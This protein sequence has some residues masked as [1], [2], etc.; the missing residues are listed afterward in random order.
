MKFVYHGMSAHLSAYNALVEQ[1]LLFGEKTAIKT[2]AYTVLY[3]GKLAHA[4]DTL[5]TGHFGHVTGDLIGDL[6]SDAVTD[7]SECFQW[8]HDVAAVSKSPDLTVLSVRVRPW[9]PLSANIRTFIDCCLA[10]GRRL[11]T[12]IFHEF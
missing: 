12:F 4:G 5:S 11:N 7:E 1:P 6:R 8:L 9:V 3:G 10:H 2:A